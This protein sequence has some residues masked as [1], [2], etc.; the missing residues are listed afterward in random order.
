MSS[1]L[2]PNVR[3]QNW[4]NGDPPYGLRGDLD[5]R[6]NRII[7]YALVRQIREKVGTCKCPK[8]M[9]D[10]VD[11][12]T[13]DLNIPIFDEEDRYISCH[14]S[15][16]NLMFRTFCFGWKPL[17]SSNCTRMNEFE[18]RTQAEREA[19]S[20]KADY[21]TYSGGGYEL[22]LK[23]HI[24]KLERKLST[25]QN[26]NWIDNRTRALIVEFSV[27]NAQ[28]MMFKHLYIMT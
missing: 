24:D 2:I 26:S 27:Y 3:V 7:G 6:V 20:L 25:I 12:C 15:F 21:N 17:V 8:L 9:R 13:G 19:G 11:S 23:G 4:Y 18:Y 14:F 1:T 28:V 10:Y 16:T 22:K 5:D